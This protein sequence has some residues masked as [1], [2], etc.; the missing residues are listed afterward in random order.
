MTDRELLILDV[1]AVAFHEKGFHGVGVDELGQR[2]GLSGPALYRH[3]SGKDELLATLL[4]RAMDELMEGLR[5]ETARPADA[6]DQAL[7]HHLRF[8]VERRDLVV[9]HER[10][11]G[12]LVEPWAAP[13]AARVQD[14]TARWE[15]LVAA[16][17]P[18]LGPNEVGVL[19]Q[20]L[21]G[22]V[23]AVSSWSSRA[24]RTGLLAEE[25]V[26]RLLQHG[27]HG[28]D[29]AIIASGSPTSTPRSAG[30]GARRTP[31]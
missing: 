1:A 13:F 16:A 27:L 6:L 15:R 17:S 30:T 7:R 18:D 2:A 8:A 10:E 24:R 20:T 9:L 25:L 26:M 22:T 5:P 29:P 19:T 21:L 14:Y 11:V 23:F 12:Y 28:L 3:F 31:Q 4:H